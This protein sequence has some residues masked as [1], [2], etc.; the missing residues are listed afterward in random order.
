MVEILTDLQTVVNFMMQNNVM[1]PTFPLKDT[2]VPAGKIGASREGLKTTPTMPQH[3]KG[4]G[5]TRR[6]SKDV[7]HPESRRAESQR[8]PRAKKTY[9]RG[10]QQIQGHGLCFDETED[11]G[12]SKKTNQ[13]ASN[14]MSKRLKSIDS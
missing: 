5:E 11:I 14:K 1:Q 6:T 9:V 2:P 3:G 7:G 10:S 12:R 4:H 8:T 13:N